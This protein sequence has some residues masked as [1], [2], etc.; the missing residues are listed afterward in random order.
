MIFLHR[1]NNLEFSIENYGIEIDLRYNEKL[2]LNHDLLEKKSVYPFLK[3]KIQFMKNIPII[4]NV[5]ESGLEEKTIELLG[6]NFEYYFLD[7]QIPDIL[8]LSK[9]GHQG[10]FIIRISDV[11][12]YNKRLMEIS[13][14][15]YVWIDYSQFFNFNLKDYQEFIYNVKPKLEQVEPILV[16]PELY[17]LSYIELIKPIQNILPK[18]FS[19][20]TKKPELWSMYV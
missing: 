7:S 2:V 18:G 1:Q 9:N 15:K 13:K 14:P 4:C 11:E 20:C 8:R 3:E 19:V 16:S 5:K 10:K 12:F 17:D 6:N